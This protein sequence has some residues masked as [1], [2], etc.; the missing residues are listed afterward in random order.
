[1]EAST[2]QASRLSDCI[3]KYPTF[4]NSA[5]FLTNGAEILSEFF[6]ETTFHQLNK[7]NVA[8]LKITKCETDGQKKSNISAIYYL[9]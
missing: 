7:G 3:G 5:P 1:M 9:T 8:L 6:Q 4:N 2:R